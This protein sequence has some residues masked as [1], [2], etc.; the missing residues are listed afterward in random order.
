MSVQ[1]IYRFGIATKFPKDKDEASYEEI[2]QVCGLSE[3][4]T[5]RIL[6]HAM[7]RRIF[8][9]RPNGMVSHTA[10]SKL[11]A[12]SPF[13]RDWSGLQTEELL[14]AATQVCGLTFFHLNWHYE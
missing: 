10:T 13:A 4:E 8:Q 5:R 14:P 6:R 7:T 3:P 1:A 11:L 12:D 2:A 9:Q